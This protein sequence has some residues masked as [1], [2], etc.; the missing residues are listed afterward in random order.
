MYNLSF[1]PLQMTP[2]AKKIKRLRLR[3]KTNPPMIP[4]KI[5]HALLLALSVRN[6]MLS[7]LNLKIM[8]CKFT[9][10]ILMACKDFWF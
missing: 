8:L 7:M 5:L 2:K 10:S 6:H 1:P 3:M 9:L 4:P